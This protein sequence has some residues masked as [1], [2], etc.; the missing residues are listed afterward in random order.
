M[1][2][3]TCDVTQ[4]ASRRVSS[5][6]VAQAAG[7]SRTTVSFVLNDRPDMA[8]PEATRR[9]VWAA[10]RELGYSPSPEA[11]ALRF[12]RSAIVLCLLPDWPIGGPFGVLLEELSTELATAGLIM[13]SHQRRTG[14]D[15]SETLAAL[16]PTA[17]VAMCDLSEDEVDLAARRG[18]ELTTFMGRVPGSTDVASFGQSDI[19]ALQ[20]RALVEHGHSALAYVSPHDRTLDWFSAPR[21]EGARREARRVGARL[22]HYRVPKS[23]HPPIRDWLANPKAK[24]VTGLCAYNDE[25][26]FSLLMA[27]SDQ[28]VSVPADLSLI[29]VDDSPISKLTRPT[30]SSVAFRL[31]E[32]AVRLA[33][34]VTG[35][36]APPQ[37]DPSADVLDLRMRASVRRL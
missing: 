11:R 2:G 36:V 34:I 15:L 10:A 9:R 6:D 29:G 32:E 25:V 20:V 13:L 30:L 16:T 37:A 17:I 7:V 23:D 35:Q 18:I 21:L 33:G 22:M 3:R 26:A 27:A 31:S 4:A 14:E 19:G 24:G 12:G 5:K 28:G 8:I 1:T